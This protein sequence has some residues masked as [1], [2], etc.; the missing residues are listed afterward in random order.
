MQTYTVLRDFPQN[1]KS[2]RKEGT[3]KLADRQAKHLLIAGFIER[4]KEEP[5]KSATKQSRKQDKGEK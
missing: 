1:G 3:I 4:K 2:Y 5:K